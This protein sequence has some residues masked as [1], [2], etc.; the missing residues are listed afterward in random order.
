[1][2]AMPDRNTKGMKAH[3]LASNVLGNEDPDIAEQRA[4]W[5]ECDKL[6]SNATGW[7]SQ[8]NMKKTTNYGRGD[9]YRSKQN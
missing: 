4:Q 7:S 2:D 6:V 9:A 8:D 1:M 5:N 3:Q